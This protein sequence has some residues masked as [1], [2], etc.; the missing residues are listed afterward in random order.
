MIQGRASVSTAR[1][2]MRANRHVAQRAFGG[3][4]PA[5][6]TARFSIRMFRERSASSDV[7]VEAI[8]RI[9]LV[10]TAT[11]LGPRKKKFANAT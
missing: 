5:Q 4:T 3:C 10:R 7:R 8:G 11:G 2:G 6:K 1:V 9:G